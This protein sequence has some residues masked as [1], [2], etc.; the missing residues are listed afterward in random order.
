MSPLIANELCYRAGL[1]GNASTD[2]LTD[3][4]AAGLYGQLVK[5]NA[6]CRR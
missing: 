1:D 6:L 2:S 3:D 4:S 5:L